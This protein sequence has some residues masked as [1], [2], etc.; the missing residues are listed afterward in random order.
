MGKQISIFIDVPSAMESYRTLLEYRPW[1]ILFCPV[2]LPDE[3][4]IKEKELFGFLLV[5]MI[6]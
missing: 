5:Y 2:Y 3:Q 6:T 1:G 4:D